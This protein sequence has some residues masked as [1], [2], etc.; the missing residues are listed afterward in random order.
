MDFNKIEITNEMLNQLAEGDLDK[1]LR[2]IMSIRNDAVFKCRF[3]ILNALD[4]ELSEFRAVESSSKLGKKTA[5]ENFK[6]LTQEEWVWFYGCKIG[7]EAAE[8]M[9]NA[10]DRW[11]ENLGPGLNWPRDII[12]DNTNALI[13]ELRI[14]DSGEER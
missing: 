13:K 12:S 11:P 10:V 5:K 7:L 3:S 1:T 2:I 4:R 14:G 6:D 8:R 9:R